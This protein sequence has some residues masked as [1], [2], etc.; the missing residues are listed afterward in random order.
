MQLL[1]NFKSFDFGEATF[2]YYGTYGPVNG[3]VIQLVQLFEGDCIVKIDKE[4][5][6]SEKR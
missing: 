5:L 2:R 6:Y 3:L 4:R 1:R